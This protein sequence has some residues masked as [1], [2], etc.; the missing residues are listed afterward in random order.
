VQIDAVEVQPDQ[1]EGKV[2]AA[3]VAQHEAAG[4]EEVPDRA[5]G[6]V[7]R[8]GGVMRREQVP[9]G[10]LVGDLGD[11]V[12]PGLRDRGSSAQLR[13]LLGVPALRTSTIAKSKAKPRNPITEATPTS[14]GGP[15]I[16]MNT[17]FPEI[18]VISHP[19][20]VMEAPFV[21]GRSSPS[22]HRFA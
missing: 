16:G 7:Q 10:D 3:F 5:E 9:A 21:S 1:A 20:S 14:K 12:E 18:V 4:V 22:R 6:G 15:S 13:R 11:A 19:C 17:V 8:R 2:C